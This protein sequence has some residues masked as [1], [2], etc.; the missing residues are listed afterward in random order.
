MSNVSNGQKKSTP[1][2]C[3]NSSPPEMEQAKINE[4]RQLIGPLSGN[5]AVYCSDASISRYLRAR[6]WNVKKA[7]KML[8]A[9]LK[10]RE[11]FKP[12]EICWDDVA[13]EAET[14][15]IYIS[16]YKDKNGRSVLVMRPRCQNSK[17][18]KGQIK[19]L[20]Y[21]MENAI[22]DLPPEQDQMIWLIDFHGF[23]VS[24]ISIK[25]TRETAHVL[26]EHYPERL[27][28][29]ILYDAPKI[30][31]PFWMVAKPFLEPKTANK[32]NFVYADDP[33]TNK[34]MSELFDME[35]VESAFGGKD[36]SDFNI[37]KY[38]ERMREDDKRTLSYWKTPSPATLV[39]SPS[40]QNLNSQKSDAQLKSQDKEHIS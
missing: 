11:E 23:N 22:L 6:N 24:H 12:E 16:N 18:I 38:A 37:T 33:N 10:W 34:I 31:Q 27:G 9:T 21:C 36:D 13:G 17:S 39:A 26:Q 30:F 1:D 3:E 5:L 40:S 4:V 14:G 29:A 15:K 28:V 32:V 25:V 2:E 7:V 19:Y 20:V 8:K 35:M